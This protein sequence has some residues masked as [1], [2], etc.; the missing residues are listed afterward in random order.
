VADPVANP[1]LILFGPL[2]PDVALRD[3]G[4]N[5]PTEKPDQMSFIFRCKF[6][7]EPSPSGRFVDVEFFAVMAKPQHQTRTPSRVG[8]FQRH[9][10]A[11]KLRHIAGL[12]RILLAP[13]DLRGNF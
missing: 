1:V 2:T 12:F 8:R 3:H 7:A 9:F 5:E 4:L 13:I 6:A 10:D 11:L